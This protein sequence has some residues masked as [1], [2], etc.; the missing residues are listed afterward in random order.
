MRRH[1]RYRLMATM[2]TLVLL[3]E[4][5]V[6]AMLFGNIMLTY[7]RNFYQDMED[8]RLWVEYFEI[9]A[10]SI[11]ELIDFLPSQDSINPLTTDRKYYV[12]LN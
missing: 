10:N 1:L 2:L 4:I 3:V 8:L 9:N 6:G 11:D 5:F 7:K 12:F